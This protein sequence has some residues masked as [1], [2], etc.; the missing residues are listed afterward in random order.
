MNEI[1]LTIIFKKKG[2]PDLPLNYRP[3][4]LVNMI[5]SFPAGRILKRLVP[6]IDGRIDKARHGFRNNISTAQ[7]LV[8]LRRTQGIQE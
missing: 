3:I 6:H 2:N 7:P 4:T 1:N 8:I 5:Y